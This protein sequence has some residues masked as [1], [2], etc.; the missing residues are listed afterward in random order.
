MLRQRGIF[1]TKCMRCCRSHLSGN[2]FIQA[3]VDSCN[4]EFDFV[5]PESK[6]IEDLISYLRSLAISRKLDFDTPGCLTDD[7]YHALTRLTKSF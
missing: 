3:A 1:V 6:E 4:P 7:D 2:Y 5:E